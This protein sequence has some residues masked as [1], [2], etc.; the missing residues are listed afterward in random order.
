MQG[1]RG[2]PSCIPSEIAVQGH[3]LGD[4]PWVS[5]RQGG[6]TSM[7]CRDRSSMR[8]SC[9]IQ[10]VV[11]TRGGQARP[12]ACLPARSTP[13]GLL[14]PG[15]QVRILCHLPQHPTFSQVPTV[16]A[17]SQDGTTRGPYSGFWYHEGKP[18]YITTLPTE[19]CL[20][21]AEIIPSDQR[22]SPHEHD[23]DL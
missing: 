18:L 16:K 8:T 5:D 21:V 10:Q 14:L 11:D 4:L 15:Q 13:A 17:H 6:F 12:G 22:S 1:C 9:P 7:C 19:T 3:C 23:F 2:H 20:F